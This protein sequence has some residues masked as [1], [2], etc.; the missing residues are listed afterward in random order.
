[1]SHYKG[2]LAETLLEGYQNATAR[3]Y[4]PPQMKLPKAGQYLQLVA[5]QDELQAVPVSAFASGVAEHAQDG[6]FLLPILAQL[7][8]HWQP[9]D[10]LSIRGPLGRG[11]ELPKRAKRVA[12]AALAGNPGRLLPLASAALTQGCEVALCT[13]AAVASL[14]AA[15]E[16]RGLADLPAVIA[17]GDYLALDI[18]IEELEVL[19]EN[20]GKSSPLPRALEAQALVD[21]P[22]P[23]GGMAKCGVC[24]VPVRKGER[25]LCEDGPVL[26]L[27]ELLVN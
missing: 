15:V 9:G 14:P 6:G 19:E 3:L 1:M 2:R 13:D 23:C 7:P 20:L 16:L 25:L 8:E 10:E 5:L 12:L 17:W 26:D 4:F 21:S 24:A 27:R 11:F 22:M 18:K